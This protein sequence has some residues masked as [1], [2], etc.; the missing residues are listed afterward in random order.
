MSAVKKNMSNMLLNTVIDFGD[1]KLTA[2]DMLE[3]I[4]EERRRLLK[5][6]GVE[7]ISELVEFIKTNRINIYEAFM[8][9]TRLAILDEME[10]SIYEE[11]I[12]N[13]N[14]YKLKKLIK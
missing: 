12:L 3:I 10:K 2:Y 9:K 14:N 7:T 11:V 6:Y 8:I 13:N 4:D 5:Q 1:I